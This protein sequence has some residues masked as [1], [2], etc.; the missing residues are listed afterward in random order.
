MTR[1]DRAGR[2]IVFAL[3]LGL[4]GSW[5]FAQSNSAGA[6]AVAKAVVTAQ[7][8][9]SSDAPA[10]ALRL[11]PIDPTL[12]DSAKRANAAAKTKKLQIGIGRDMSE[13][14]RASSQ[15]LLWSSVPGGVA[16]RLEITSPNASA[17]R[18]AL[19]SARIGPGL[20]LRFAG[21]AHPDMVYGPFSARDVDRSI[22]MYWSPVLEGETA[23]VEFFMSAD[24]SVVDVAPA[25]TQVSHLF[26]NPAD[27]KADTL[28]KIGESGSCEVN[29]ICR[30]ASDTALANAGRAVARMVFSDGLGGGQF[31]CTGTL[32]NPGDGSFTPYFYTAA[33]CIS[34][35]ASASTLTTYWFYDS[36]S[37]NTNVLNPATT[38]LPG[39]ATLLYAN[40]SNDP[41]FMRLNS[42]PPNGAIWAAWD[43]A[44][45]SGAPALTGI[46]HPKGDVKKVSLGTFG[47]FN[48]GDSSPFSG[49]TFI[50]SNWNSTATGVT[51][52]GSSGSGIF[53]A[54]GTPASE[55]RLRGGLQGGPSSCFASGSDLQDYYS[56]FDL[57]YPQIAQYL[58]TPSSPV[59]YT[60][61]YWNPNESGWGLN[62]NHQDDTIF[63]T[64]FDYDANGQPF[65]LVST[66]S[67]QSSS[68]GGTDIFSGDLLLTTGPAFNAN[69]FT[70]IDASNITTVG[71]MTLA[72]SSNGGGGGLSYS[73]N[74]I[75]VTKTITKQQVG[76]RLA[77]CVGTTGDR[78]GLTNYQ[79]LWWASP[80][81]SESGW[82]VNITHDGDTIFATLF[83]YANAGQGTHNPGTW[84]V[85]TATRQS[86]GSFSGSLLSTTGPAFNANP[87][88][89][90]GAGNI[91]TVGTM[92]FSFA[93]GTSGTMTYT[94]NGVFVQKTIIRQVFGSPTPACT[95]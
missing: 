46:H 20:E 4:F 61:L 25:V 78:S 83:T 93:N 12:I 94:V 49:N 74:G 69:P 58:G 89:P 57:A 42:T 95:S 18:V 77:T 88:T 41:S 62:V 79:D 35:Q 38:Q 90:I 17:L 53:T 27:A 24:P 44:T 66:M 47:G 19:T 59:N 9:L 1:F 34:T 22:P 51:E 56:R 48:G 87:F 15:A 6:P 26:V 40:T 75:Q 14:L 65:W 68:G 64:L 70:P 21:S 8:L 86:D 33:H 73:V 16:A 63:A 13:E 11:D 85:T 31:L 3:F 39:G 10:V 60:A 81:N 52:P 84:Y 43:A 37:C 7:F 80:A 30:S 23:I 91:S 82:G 67:K 54:F 50:I 28:A 45:L 92:R 2:G 55:Y 76:P 29:L 72:L 32:L 5:A 36:T 71:S